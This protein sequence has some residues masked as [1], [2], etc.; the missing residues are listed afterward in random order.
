MF[1]T[2]VPVFQVTLSGASSERVNHLEDLIRGR[3]ADGSATG[4]A[5]APSEPQHP[6]WI[7]LTDESGSDD[8]VIGSTGLDNIAA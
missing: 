1:D 2:F 7:E 5:D 6:P 4:L 3:V 8:P